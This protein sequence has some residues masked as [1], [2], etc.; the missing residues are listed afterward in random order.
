VIAISGKY[1]RNGKIPQ[2]IESILGPTK[3]PKVLYLNAFLTM[4]RQYFN[5]RS[6]PGLLEKLKGN[7]AAISSKMNEPMPRRF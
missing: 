3:F 4:H 5:L 2:Y 6:Q 1:H 7:I